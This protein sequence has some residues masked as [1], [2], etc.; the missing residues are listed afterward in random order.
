MRNETTIRR[1][2]DKLLKSKFAHMH[3]KEILV[4][5]WVLTHKEEKK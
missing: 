2:L 3:Q 1:R 4:L 5:R